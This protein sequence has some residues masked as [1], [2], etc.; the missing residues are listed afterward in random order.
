MVLLCIRFGVRLPVRSFGAK[1]FCFDLGAMEPSFYVSRLAPVRV[2]ATRTPTHTSSQFEVLIPQSSFGGIHAF[3][4]VS[5]KTLGAH[6]RRIE[7]CAEQSCIAIMLRRK[8]T[9]LEI[10]Q[11]DIEELDQS[12][13]QMREKLEQEAK[14]KDQHHPA[15]FE[16]RTAREK[17][18]LGMSLRE[19]LG[20]TKD[21]AS[22]GQ[23]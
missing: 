4:G 10:D 20:L 14:G 7:Q 5:L 16:D 6:Q 3:F 21:S 9:F 22:Q 17:A 13:R 11:A 12:R 8:P 1:T 18:V 23:I 19:R 15:V 2:E